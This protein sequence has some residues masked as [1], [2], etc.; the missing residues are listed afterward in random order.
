[1]GN[2]WGIVVLQCGSPLIWRY[3]VLEPKQK[4]SSVL[5]AIE[6]SSFRTSYM[7]HLYPGC[8]HNYKVPSLGASVRLFRL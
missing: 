4:Y 7:D 5:H 1:M 8:C 3:Y 6:A 2:S